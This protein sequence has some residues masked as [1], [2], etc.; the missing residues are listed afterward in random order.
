M[1]INIE[2]PGTVRLAREVA[3]LTGESLTQAAHV[4]LQEKLAKLRLSKIADDAPRA[5]SIQPLTP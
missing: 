4:A 1:A 2:R 3:V 5:R